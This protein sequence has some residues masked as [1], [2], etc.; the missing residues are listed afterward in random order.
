M[1]KYLILLNLLFTSTIYANN[2]D[3][4]SIYASLKKDS[5]SYNYLP[6]KL[7]KN[8]DIAM[9]DSLHLSWGV[10]HINVKITKIYEVIIG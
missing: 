9:F 10:M 8:K 4:T 6:K 3:Y 5:Y 1:N 2:I 7:Q